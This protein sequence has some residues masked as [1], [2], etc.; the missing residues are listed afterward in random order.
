M[1]TPLFRPEVTLAKQASWL[2]GIHLAHNPRFSLMAGV[3]LA[4]ASALMAFGA[5]G[6]VARKVRVPGVLMP[7]WGTVELS[8]A[9]SGVLLEQRV[10]E[11]DWVQQGQV[12]FVVNTDKTSAEGSS[13]SL[14]ASH[15]AQ[16]RSTLLAERASRMAQ[17]RQREA[18]LTDRIRSLSLETAQATQEQALSKRRVELAQ[19]T[20]ARFEQM[21][22]EGFVSDI[23]AQGKQFGRTQANAAKKIQVEFVS[24]NPTSSL[25]VGHGRGAAYGMTVATLLEATGA[26]VDREYYVND[27]GR[28][29]DILA[30]STY[31]R[32]LELTGQELVFPKNAYQGDYVKE[33]AQSIIDAD[34]DAYVRPVADVYKDVPEDVQYAEE[35][36]A[37]GNKV[38]LSGDKEKHIDGLIH[39]L[40]SLI[41]EAY[42]VFHQA[43]LNA[44]LDDIKDDLGEFGVTFNQWFSEASLTD[45][46]DE[47]LETLEQRGFLYEKDGNIWFKSTEFGDE[48]DR[49]VK[50]RNGQTTYFASDIAY[51]LNKLQRG[52]TDIIDIWG[53]DHHGYISRVKAAIDALGYDSKKLTVLLVQFVS[54]WR[55]GEMVQMSS[56]SG[57]FVTLRDLRKEVGNDAARFYYVMRKSEQHID[58]DL[59]LAVSQSKDN[60][61]YYIQYA[62]ARVNR[63]VD[64]KAPEK[65]ISFDRS[66]AADYDAT[67]LTLDAETEILAK[68]AAYPEIVLRAANSYEPHQVGNYL[69]ELAALFHGWYNLDNTRIIDE[70]NIALSQ[71]RLLLSINVQQVLRNGLELLGVSAPEAM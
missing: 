2:G 4:L 27:A 71:A 18:H 33:I 53:S 44:I 43:A 29:M 13:A 48:K 56:R 47:A 46:I 3:A 14:L 32:Y 22:A 1:T 10:K 19:K 42:R 23:Q 57:Q 41:G 11:G 26:T 15:L 61:V 40:Q 68:L 8:P 30:T 34:G 28:Q 36:D 39:N 5:W 52:Y 70:Q 69:K 66:K 45:K 25:H 20:S 6:K 16:R 54:L 65:G 60:A 67:L 35:L 17:N 12:L 21:A 55:G 49:V 24:A 31:L 9:V 58:F 59:D 51:H 50:R 63:M 62:H 38:V 64:V 37:E 7:Q